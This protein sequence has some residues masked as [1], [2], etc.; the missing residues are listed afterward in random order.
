MVR[1]SN[2]WRIL[3]KQRSFPAPAP[4]GDIG[5]GQRYGNG[6]AFDLGGPE[7]IGAFFDLSAARF[8]KQR[9]ADQG[10][11]GKSRRFGPTGL[12][13]ADRQG[14]VSLSQAK[15]KG[16]GLAAGTFLIIL[17]FLQ[18]KA[19]VSRLYISVLI[20]IYIRI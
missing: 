20:Q 14:T 8:S 18:K 19:G 10:F 7:V 17:H 1:A 6:F 15:F 9:T 5:F 16:E 3:C 11:R 4:R 12:A 13:S 2:C